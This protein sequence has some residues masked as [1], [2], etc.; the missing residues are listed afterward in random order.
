MSKQQVK[1]TQRGDGR[2]MLFSTDN[3]QA[4]GR[5]GGV[6]RSCNPKKP[7]M[8]TLFYKFSVGLSNHARNEEYKKLRHAKKALKKWGMPQ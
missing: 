8:A 7:W 2:I 1:L 5:Y 4:G 6:V 3:P